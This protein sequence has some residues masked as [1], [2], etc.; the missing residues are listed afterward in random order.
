M[1]LT[2]V[3]I[4]TEDVKGLSD[5]YAKVLKIDPDFYGDYAEL[6]T[7]VGTLA[8]FDVDSYEKLAGDKAVPKSN[9]CAILEFN[10]EDVNAEFE[11]IKETGAEIVKPLTTQPWGSRSF[12]F[13]DPDGNLVNFYSRV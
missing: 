8:L 1:K 10:V 12:Y 5:F 2:H 13:R 11:R 6:K 4:I 3:C 9:R 7:D